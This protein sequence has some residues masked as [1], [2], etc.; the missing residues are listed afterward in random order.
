MSLVKLTAK[1]LSQEEV[2]TLLGILGEL[3]TKSGV[4]PLAMTIKLQADAMVAAEQA[5]QT[6]QKAE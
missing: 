5:A 1:K 6:E 3:P 2:V 4:F